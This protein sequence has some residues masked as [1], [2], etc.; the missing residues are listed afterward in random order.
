MLFIS[1][2]AQ[3]IQV[4]DTIMYKDVIVGIIHNYAIDNSKKKV[5]YTIDVIV[6]RS[7]YT[8]NQIIRYETYY[9]KA[10][11]IK[12]KFKMS[13]YNSNYNPNIDVEDIDVIMIKSDGQYYYPGTAAY[14]LDKSGEAGNDALI[15]GGITLVAGTLATL[16]FPPV[17]IGVCVAGT[18]VV[19]VKKV[20]HNN[21]LRRAAKILNKK[22]I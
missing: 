2:K 5:R 19:I 22:G 6:S 8:S 21:E 4:G 16:A 13:T 15:A 20:Q 7:S 9:G 11:G 1:V 17:G 14:H 3:S 18:V 12:V 10:N